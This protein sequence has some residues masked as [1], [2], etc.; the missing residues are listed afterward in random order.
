MEKCTN[1]PQCPE[2]APQCNLK[3]MYINNYY[4]PQNAAQREFKPSQATRQA[5]TVQQMQ[6]QTKNNAHN[7][8]KTRSERDNVP[9]H[10]SHTPKKKNA[11]QSA[12]KRP[13]RQKEKPPTIQRPPT[14]FLIVFQ[15]FPEKEQSYNY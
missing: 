5:K 12:K 1:R 3:S 13:A 10:Y 4:T 8:Q 6:T 2:N 15:K 11:P 14:A 7:R 9:P